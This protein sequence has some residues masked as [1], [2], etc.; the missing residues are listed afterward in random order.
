MTSKESTRVNLH[1]VMFTTKL[2]AANSWLY[3]VKTFFLPMSKILIDFKVLEQGLGNILASRRAPA[4][5]A[6]AGLTKKTTLI[7]LCYLDLAI[8]Q[9]IYMY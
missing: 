7:F 2:S 8:G 3:F 6:T 9:L 5:T 4:A 1:L